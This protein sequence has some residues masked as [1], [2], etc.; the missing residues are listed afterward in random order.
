MMES[1]ISPVD[2]ETRAVAAVTDIGKTD[3]TEAFSGIVVDDISYGN[4]TSYFSNSPGQYIVNITPYNNNSTV[5]YAFDF[6]ISGYAGQSGVIFS[7]GFD[8][9]SQNQNGASFALCAA[10]STGSVICF[11]NV[12]GSDEINAIE[13]FDM[14]PNPAIND[15]LLNLNF[16]KDALLFITNLA[17]Q[18]V[19]QLSV[20]K[21][22][23]RLIIPVSGFANG[24]YHIRISSESESVNVKFAVQR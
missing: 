15:L 4:I 6:N 5:L 23:N 24:L 16:K 14:Y 13:H 19:F 9:P 17:G 22:T 8:D 2:F 21:E 20:K 1:A 3:A 7:S 11:S 10:L 12:T 18:N